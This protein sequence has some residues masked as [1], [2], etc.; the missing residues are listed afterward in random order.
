VQIARLAAEGMEE[1]DARARLAAQLP[2]EEKARSADVLLDNDG[3]LEELETQVDR[4]WADLAA[5]SAAR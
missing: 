1:A 3:T 4:L 2:L 5:R